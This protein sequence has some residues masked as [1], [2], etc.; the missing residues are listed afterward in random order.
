LLSEA[1]KWS[2][3][4]LAALDA[5]TRGSRREMLLQSTFAISAMWLRGNNDEVLA[6]IARGLQ[7]APADDEPSQRLR[8]LA[9]RHLFLTRIA[10][11]H[12][13]LAA[14]DEW[15]AAAK[16][17]GDVSC[18]AISDLM[19]GV[20]LHFKGDQAAARKYFDAGFSQAGARNLQLCGNDHRV[21]GLVALSRALGVSGQP[22]RSV[23]TARHAV[24]TAMRFGKPLDTCFALIFT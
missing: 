4:G 2:A 19:H 7:L 22:V 18:L 10:D 15:D 20:A 11:F 3:A 9:T 1:Y 16:Q 24:G 13:A 8:M 23:D 17:V 21:R 6:A 14:A 12:G 5:T